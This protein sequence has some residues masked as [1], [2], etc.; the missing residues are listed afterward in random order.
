MAES[1]DAPHQTHLSKETV[2]KRE[3]KEVAT[4][5]RHM[6]P[7]NQAEVVGQVF[8]RQAAK[9]VSKQYSG[10]VNFLREQ[11]VIG[12]GIG[13]VLGSQMKVVVDSVM[14]GLVNPI[15][16]LFLPGQQRLSEKVVAIHFAGRSTT[17]AWGSV[18]FALLNFVLVAF[19]I[20]AIFKLLKLDK[21]SKK[22]D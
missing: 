6:G 21:L 3:V 16:L 14:N 20:Y 18:A 15:T 7:V 19:I 4:K 10:F 2:K 17:I 5:L 1:K 22:K 8:T 13:L 11:S 12:I 9:Q